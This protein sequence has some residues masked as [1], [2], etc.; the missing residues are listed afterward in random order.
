MQKAFEDFLYFKM[1]KA[2]E[3]IQDSLAK[4]KDRKSKG[5][6]KEKSSISRGLTEKSDPGF[7]V[8]V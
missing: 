6:N 5:K 3:T 1:Q 8:I 2:I 7:A 4:S